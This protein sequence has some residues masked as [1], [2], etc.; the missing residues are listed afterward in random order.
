MQISLVGFAARDKAI[1]GMNYLVNGVKSTLGPFS[2]DF[3]LEKGNRV[4]NDGYTVSKAVC[5]A[6]PDEFERRGANVIH[7]ASAKTNDQVGDATTTSE[8]LAQAIVGEAIKYLPKQGVVG[9]R[10][11]TAIKA[12]INKEKDEVI[13]KLEASV[14]KIESEEELIN[15]AKVSVE[16]EE[17]ASLMG[18]AQWQIG[19]EGMI[20]A[21]ETAEYQ[22]SIQNVKGVRIDNGFASSALI[23]NQEKQTIEAENCKVILTNYVLHNLF[24]FEKV[25]AELTKSE[26][27]NRQLIII[28]RA[29]S[30]ECIQVI[31][32]N[33]LN[34]FK[35]Y[36]I[37]APFVNQREIMKDLEIILGGRY[38]E[39]EDQNPNPIEE[40]LP[41]DLG[42]CSKMIA[43]RNDAIFT[44][45][46]DTLA[47]ANIVARI[48]EIKGGLKAS[49]SEFEKKAI[50]A[51]IS[52]LTNGFAILKVGAETDVER[53][54]KKDKCD[55]ATNAVRLALKGGTVKGGGLAFKEIADT[56]PQDSLLKK[57]LNCVYDQ[58]MSS[59][60][61]GFVIPEWCR[62]PFL[63]LKAALIN[64]CSVAGT[65]CAIQGIVTAENEH[66]CKCAQVI[67]EEENANN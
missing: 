55:D 50:Q 51:R 10:T 44:G 66:K 60:P 4:T 36:P 56:M 33:F 67:K 47:Q 27:I 28:A 18:K 5:D 15:S 13:K 37:N 42:F 23:N 2:S 45:A 7:E 30:S 54:R 20:I 17:L 12:K 53:K 26:N 40:V 8:M 57:P 19:E 31:Y 62:D 34:G 49:V 16:D 25:F 41:S 39:T 63:V 65:F 38:I 64:A 14:K 58:I 3:L 43:R 61:E 1:Q 32:K 35:I 24:G 22:S 59:A 11:V 21:E 52:Q 46:D 9:K 29:F 6:I 48:S